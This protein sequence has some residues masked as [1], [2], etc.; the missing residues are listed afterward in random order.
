MADAKNT[1]TPKPKFTTAEIIT[2]IVLV[3]ISVVVFVG[4][5]WKFHDTCGDG[6]VMAILKSIGLQCLSSCIL[7]LIASVFWMTGNTSDK[8]P[9]AISP[10]SPSGSLLSSVLVIL[11]YVFFSRNCV[12]AVTTSMY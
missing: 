6:W 11:L 9:R 7:I 8:I 1:T 12:S 3:L 5:A 10:T 2:A 4:V